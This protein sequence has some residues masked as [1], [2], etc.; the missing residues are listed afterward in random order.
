MELKVL[1]DLAGGG[2]CSPHTTKKHFNKV[3]FCLSRCR[4]PGA[5]R[6]VQL[7]DLFTPQTLEIYPQR[8]PN[9][10]GSVIRARGFHQSHRE[11]QIVSA[12]PIAS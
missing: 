9:R 10:H 1:K 6:R 2:A 8:R 12:L 7:P 4:A 5:S 3:K 11:K